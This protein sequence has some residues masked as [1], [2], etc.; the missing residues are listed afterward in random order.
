MYTFGGLFIY[1]LNV[2][3]KQE[4]EFA[5]RLLNIL[6]NNFCA[7]ENFQIPYYYSFYESFVSSRVRCS[8]L[9][10]ITKAKRISLRQQK[11]KRRAISA[12]RNL[13]QHDFS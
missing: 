10:N 12:I 13:Q 8:Y 9:S 4:T 6:H 1:L 3:A 5:W 7:F 2:Y 11:K